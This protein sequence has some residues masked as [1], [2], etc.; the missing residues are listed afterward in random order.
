MLFL[1]LLLVITLIAILA[2]YEPEIDIVLS[3]DKRIFLLWYN[4]IEDEYASRTY[5]K[6]FEI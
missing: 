5:I 2:R 1:I 4:K 6:L 3:K